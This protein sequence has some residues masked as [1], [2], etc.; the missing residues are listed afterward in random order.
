MFHSRLASLFAA[1]LF[2]CLALASHAQGTG[3]ALPLQMIGAE[4][5]QRLKAVTGI[6]LLSVNWNGRTNCGGFAEARLLSLSFDRMPDA[7]GDDAPG[8]LVVDDPRPGTVD[9]AFVVPPG[10]YALSGY[11]V[12]VAKS[13]GDSGGFRAARS[14]LVKDG[15]PL[16]GGFEV[17][18]GEIVYVGDFSLECRDQ[19]MPWRSFPEG[20]AEFQEYLGRVKSRFPSLETGRAQFRP[21]VTSKFGRFYAAIPALQD[22]AAPQVVELARKAEAGDVEAQYQ[23]GA[24]YD[25]GRDVRRDLP[26]AIRWYRRAADAGHIEAQNS[27]GSALQAEG[28]YEEAAAWYEKAAARGH[29]R[30]VS[31]LAALY[32]AGLGVAQDRNKAFDLWA[33]AAEF[34]WAEAMWNL[35][36]L[37]RTGA[38][39]ERSLAASCAWNVLARQYARP[40]EHALL[41]RIDQTNAFLEQNL[42]AGELAACRNLAVEW[43]P[44][45]VRPPPPRQ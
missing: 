24:A 29:M 6:V 32:D 28:R 45:S 7:R 26:E 38:L 17:R 34:G 9:Y 27:V 1:P 8:D 15:L 36:N 31:N 43:A 35:A 22:A 30:S 20:P 42:H 5:F 23:L 40:Y 44:R 11:D 14:K 19:P 25:A 33:R 12:R 39:R 13:A 4:A 2:L 41:A 3:T 10:G 16:G 18:A 37:Y 21:M